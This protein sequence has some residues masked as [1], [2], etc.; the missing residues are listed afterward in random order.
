V[1]DKE[2]KFPW[3]ESVDVYD[4]T[5]FNSIQTQKFIEELDEL[6]GYAVAEEEKKLIE[7]LVDFSRQIKR[8]LFLRVVGD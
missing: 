3:L 7:S 2:A 8:G 1:E 6:R 4:D 5:I